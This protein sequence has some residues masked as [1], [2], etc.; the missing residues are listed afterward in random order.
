[1]LIFNMLKIFKEPIL[2]DHYNSN[3]YIKLKKFL[4]H[5]EVKDVKCKINNKEPK[6]LVPFIALSVML[7][8]S[9][10]YIYLNTIIK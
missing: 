7:P 1:M 10:I 4:S 6:L 8:A 5:D 2:K 3:G 9:A